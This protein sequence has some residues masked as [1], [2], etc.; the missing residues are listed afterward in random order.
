MTGFPPLRQTQPYKCAALALRLAICACA[1]FCMAWPALSQ[2]PDAA[3]APLR[4]DINR[5]EITGNTLLKPAEMARIVAPFTGRQKDFS[6]VQRALEA[7]NLLIGAGGAT[8]S[9]TGTGGYVVGAAGN[10]LLN[11]G[12]PASG[13][14]ILA[15]GNNITVAASG[16]SNTGDIALSAGG[17]VLIGGNL[18]AGNNMAIAA[19]NNVSILDAVASSTGT[20]TVNAA[21][22]DVTATASFTQ[23]RGGSTF[24]AVIGGMTTL[25]GGAGAAAEVTN[26]GAGIFNFSTGALTVSGGSGAGGYARLFG[27]PDVRL[28][29]NAGAV[30][31]NAGSAGAYA[32]VEAVS[33]TSVYVNFPNLTANGYS[34]NGVV[35]AVY[36]APTQ[37]GFVAGGLPAILATNL[38]VTYGGVVVTVPPP[39]VQQQ[40]NQAIQQISQLTTPPQPASPPAD[41][42]EEVGTG[43]G[44]SA[45]TGTGTGNNSAGG[46][47][48]TRK[49]P[50]CR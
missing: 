39:A 16:Y 1:I 34:V 30:S 20:L 11:N 37:S 42:T 28:T 15:A 8:F 43:T 23:M 12:A 48:V 9:N 3:P 22:L 10:I 45:S 7:G 40:I 46:K 25:Q 41:P 36:D 44:S 29:V 32:A 2:Q 4:F 38:I 5:Y 17:N 26:S 13:N 33:P 24:T 50:V 14:M 27:N 18:S 35:N 31:L 19:G 6:D 21:S 49:V 47:T